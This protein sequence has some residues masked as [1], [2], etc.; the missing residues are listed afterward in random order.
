MKAENAAE[1]RGRILIVD[2]SELN[3]MTLAE[4]LTSNSYDILEASGGVEAISLLQSTGG[5]IDL[6]LLDLYMPDIDGFGVLTMMHKHHWCDQVPI[7]MISVEDS[8]EAIRKALFLGAADYIRK[9]YNEKL[10]IRRVSSVLALYG[11]LRDVQDSSVRENTINLQQFYRAKIQGDEWEKREFFA[12]DHDILQIEYDAEFDTAILSPSSARVFGIEQIIAVPK[13]HM[14]FPISRESLRE[15]VHAVRATTPE[16]PDTTVDVFVNRLPYYGWYQAYAKSLWAEQSGE[17]R[18]NGALVKVIRQERNLRAREQKPFRQ[19]PGSDAGSSNEEAMLEIRGSIQDFGYM[20]DMLRVFFDIVRMVPVRDSG[21]DNLEQG[22]NVHDGCCGKGNAH[23]HVD[24][25]CSKE[26]GND[27]SE[28]C[29]ILSG[30][31]GRC[32]DCITMK[33]YRQKSRFSEVVS[34]GD[35]CYFAYAEYVQV[36][37]KDYVLE[38]VTKI[39]E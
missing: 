23:T 13:N 6:V 20:M 8:Q 33:A 1:K 17:L 3:R 12:S 21:F 16:N 34:D 5:Q 9:P 14:E 29:H 22:E 31:P 2:D 27:T 24:H 11:G 25:Q 39:K 18:Y 35:E 36:G 37:E 15:L 38:M 4:I 32:P 28:R 10:I 30:K 26:N 19:D 7:I